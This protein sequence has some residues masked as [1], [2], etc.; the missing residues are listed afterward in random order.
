MA[1]NEKEARD[2]YRREELLQALPILEE[3][4]FGLDQNQVHTSG[5]RYLMAGARDVG[6]GGRKLVLTGTQRGGKKAVLKISS[7][8]EGVREIE[9]ERTARQ[10]LAKIPFTLSTFHIPEELLF[11]KRGKHSIFATK[12]IEQEVPLLARALDEQFFLILRAFETQEGVH[13]TTSKHAAVIRDTFGMIGAEEYLK[14]F[15]TFSEG[16]LKAVPEDTELALAL[17]RAREFLQ[18][19]KTVIE[20]Y[21]GFLTHADFVPNNLRVEGT[22]LYLLDYASLHFGNKYESWARFLNYMVHHNPALE[23]ALLDYVRKNR[24]PEEYLC[25]RLMRAYKLGFLLQFYAKALMLTQGD[26][27][28]II[29]ARVLFWTK[30]L[31]CI[32]ADAPLPSADVNELVRLEAELRT[33]EEKARQSELIGTRVGGL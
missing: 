24:G 25:L 5:E 29:Q 2:A 27:R 13:A 12:Y 32:L 17:G 15:D 31:N 1:A 14:N 11:E 21:S 16:A 22:T 18:A 4:G 3:L 33:E 28:K 6:G 8:D 7:E 20:R 30:V 23:H 9:R 19:N 10:V 26:T